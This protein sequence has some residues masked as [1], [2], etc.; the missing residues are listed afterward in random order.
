M[1][2]ITFSSNQFE[3][4]S[5][6]GIGAELQLHLTSELNLQNSWILVSDLKVGDLVKTNTGTAKVMR[7]TF[8]DI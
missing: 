1:Y 3:I 2:K 8:L 4:E 7:I 5:I 6:Y